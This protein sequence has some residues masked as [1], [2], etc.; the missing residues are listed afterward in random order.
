MRRALWLLPWLCLS[1]CPADNT[2][3]SGAVCSAASDCPAPITACETVACRDGACVH[4][5]LAAGAAVPQQTAGDCRRNVCDSNGKIVSTNDPTDV[6]SDG[7]DCTADSCAQGVSVH[8]PADAGTACGTLANLACDGAGHC[9]GCMS[10]SDCAPGDECKDP[11]CNAGLCGFVPKARGTA[12]SAQTS[13]DCKKAQ[14]DGQG[15]TEMVDDDSDVPSDN[16]TCTAD[17]CA[18]GSPV[19]A[20]VQSYTPCNENGGAFCDGAGACKQ[21]LIATDCAGTDGICVRRVCSAGVCGV[22]AD[23]AGTPLASQTAGDC[24]TSVCDGDG[25][26]AK[27]NDNTDLP[28]DNNPCTANACSNGAPVFPPLDAGTSCGGALL[29]NGSGACVGCI[30]PG[31]CGADDVCRTRTCTGGTCGLLLTDAGTAV[32][33]QTGGDCRLNV[34]DTQG[35][36]VAVND[37]TDL[38][39]DDG[40]PCTTESCSS[41]VPSHNNLATN[42]PCV[43]D[44]GSFCSPAGACVE[45]NAAMQCAG[46]DTDCRARACAS[47]RCGF[48][49]APA[50]TVTATQTPGDCLQNRCDGDGGVVQVAFT[51]DTPADDG[52]QCT[53]EACDGGVPVHPAQAADFACSEGSGRYCNGVGT[54]VE[55]NHAAQCPSMVCAVNSTC[56]MPSCSDMVQN[57]AET[58]VDCGGG[59]CPQCA[60]TKHCSG[61]SDCASGTC[62]SGTCA[63]SCSTTGE[64]CS[65]YCT[66]MLSACS[67]VFADMA[68]CLTACNAFDDSQICCR[69][70]HCGFAMSDPGTHCPHASGMS[71]CP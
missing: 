56:A 28:N 40:N 46:T 21:C 16:E 13:G 58:D 26:V 35:N 30:V 7:N 14:C 69:G 8:S 18:A 52:E 65:D 15:G 20:P 27:V 1:G 24:Q 47:N 22:R 51:T 68:A 38:P 10:P 34:C 33:M 63:L 25:G 43:S 70:T 36:V 50:T 23:D 9:R 5:R 45:C 55:C 71:L 54:C 4:T 12:V 6:M 44:G 49:N 66:C 60:N 42:T 19:H 53:A 62:S 48:T 31:D 67:T 3:D 37:D 39:A 2:Q 61:N 57:G 64:T 29:C 11:T 32:P 59:T 17:S 41:G